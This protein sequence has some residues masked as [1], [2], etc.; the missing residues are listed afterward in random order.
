[1]TL[2]E[3]IEILNLSYVKEAMRVFIE[4]F[5]KRQARWVKISID[6]RDGLYYCSACH[7]SIDIADGK[8][9]PLDRDIFYCPNCGAKM[10]GERKDGETE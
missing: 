6:P 4:V 10:N 7:E 3:A 5:N 9:T 1:M 2:D 8:E